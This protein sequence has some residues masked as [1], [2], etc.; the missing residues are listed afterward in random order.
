[1]P[2]TGY[3]TRLANHIPPNVKLRIDEGDTPN[4]WDNYRGD[5]LIMP[6]RFGGLCLPVNEA[7]AAGMPAI[8]PNISP[9]EWL[10]TEWLVNAGWC[11]TFK[12]KQRVDIYSANHKALA[13][14]IDQFTDASF[15]TAAKVKAADL[16]RGL[17]WH[18]LLPEYQKALG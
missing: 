14:K 6:R 2:T 7:L 8:M 15:Y 18:T 4:Y 5:V 12:A 17:S 9:N 3:V 11:T 13:A 10:P 1:M 16:A